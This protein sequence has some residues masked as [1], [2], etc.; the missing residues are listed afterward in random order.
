MISNKGE[1]NKKV[2]RVVPRD[3]MGGMS[4]RDGGTSSGI[5]PMYGQTRSSSGDAR[6]CIGIIIVLIIIVAIIMIYNQFF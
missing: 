6:C 3:D 4:A 2:L 1:E 5:G